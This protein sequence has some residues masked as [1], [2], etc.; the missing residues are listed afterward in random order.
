MC[1]VC[2]SVMTRNL[3]VSVCD[4]DPTKNRAIV[5]GVNIVKKHTKH[6]LSQARWYTH[7]THDSTRH[8]LAHTLAH[9]TDSHIYR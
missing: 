6:W 5:E 8:T 4:A 1:D 3:A 7:D 9:Y 2:V